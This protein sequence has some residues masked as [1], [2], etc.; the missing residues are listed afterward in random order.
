MRSIAFVSV[1]ALAAGLSAAADDAWLPLSKGAKWTYEIQEV[2]NVAGFVTA[3]KTGSATCTCKEG[4]KIGD[5]NS[6]ILTWSGEGEDAPDGQVWVSC[7][8]SSVIVARST[9]Q[10]LW[11]VPADFDKKTCEVKVAG[12]KG[13]I[14]ISSTVDA[15]EEEIEVPA[16]K[17]KC[18]KVTARCDVGGGVK[19]ERIVW[20]AKGVGIVKRVNRADVGGGV[21]ADHAFVLVKFEAGEA[22][23]GK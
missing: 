3:K 8:P 15:A 14:S 22:A 6:W 23:G 11:V 13:S 5:V 21:S 2:A 4:E 17:F 16:G 18:R 12:E 7:G 1:L 9:A 19:T 10:E 20:Y